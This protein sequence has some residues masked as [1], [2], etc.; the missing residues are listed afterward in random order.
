VRLADRRLQAVLRK[1]RLDPRDEVSTIGLV[2]G[3][4]ELASAAFREMTARRIL[5]VRARRERS[6]VE[7]SITRHSERHMPPA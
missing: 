2:V 1:R 6:I 4:L 3:V 5:M 7:Q